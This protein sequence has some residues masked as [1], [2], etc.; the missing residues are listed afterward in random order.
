MNQ[1]EYII[2][3]AIWFQDEK[4]YEHQPININTGFVVCGLRHHNCFMTVS[5]IKNESCKVSDYGKNIQGFLTNKNRFV[6]R[7]EAATIALNAKQINEPTE[8]LFSEDLY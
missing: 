2:C 4:K 8:V 6:D 3:A 5:I 1:T 7:K